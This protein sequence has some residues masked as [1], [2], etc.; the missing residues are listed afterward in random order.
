MH[1]PS[2][3]QFLTAHSQT[4]LPVGGPTNYAM[5]DTYVNFTKKETY[6]FVL[7]TTFFWVLILTFLR[8]KK[9]RQASCRRQRAVCPH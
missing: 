3:I 2:T 4:S 1:L 9:T 7:K 8:L 5:A 6:L